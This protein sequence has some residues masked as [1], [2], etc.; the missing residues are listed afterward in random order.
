MT[1]LSLIWDIFP[2]LKTCCPWWVS[3]QRSIRTFLI[4]YHHIFIMY[5]TW[6]LK[7]C[8]KWSS[9]HQPFCSHC[10]VWI[11]ASWL[12]LP[13]LGPQGSLAAVA[14]VKDILPI[15][16]HSHGEVLSWRRQWERR[17]ISDPFSLWSNSE[18]GSKNLV[19]WQ[20]QTQTRCLP[21]TSSCMC[22]TCWSMCHKGTLPSA[23]PILCWDA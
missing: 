13:L 8:R 15:M 23:L 18:I 16:P 2:V 5:G 1:T 22:A 9:V 19:S 11:T 7:S 20:G 14:A 3:G 12:I 17:E 10:T 21:D 6:P 4:F